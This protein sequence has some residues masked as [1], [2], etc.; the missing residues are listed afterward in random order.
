MANR[1]FDFGKIKKSFFTTRL[2]DGR[3]LAVNMPK[4]RVL[5][6]IIGTGESEENE[7]EFDK[8]V[9]ELMAEVLSNNKNGKRITAE[10]VKNNFD[11]EDI[12]E[13]LKGYVDFVST[14]N[15]NPN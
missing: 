13:Y 6:M 5:E 9:F 11:L 3:V 15:V 8:Q 2:R 7:T 12:V 4:K 14:L 10:E 1:S